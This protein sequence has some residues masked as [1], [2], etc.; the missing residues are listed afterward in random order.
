MRLTLFPKRRFRIDSWNF[1]SHQEALFGY[2][3]KSSLVGPSE[4]V[5]FAIPVTALNQTLGPRENKLSPAASFQSAHDASI[6]DECRQII[7]FG[8][9][10]SYSKC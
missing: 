9:D 4:Q 1:T 6:R 8:K 7:E 3:A 2:S 5:L 10:G